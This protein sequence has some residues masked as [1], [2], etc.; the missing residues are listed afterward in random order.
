MI[1]QRQSRSTLMSRYQVLEA[2]WQMHRARRRY[3]WRV[4]VRS[5]S[6]GVSEKKNLHHKRRRS[7]SQPSRDPQTKSV[8]LVA[9]FSSLKR[10]IRLILSMTVSSTTISSTHLTLRL[11]GLTPR[12]SHR[13]FQRKLMSI[14]KS[15][16]CSNAN[17]SH[18]SI[19]T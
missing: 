3:Q 10:S 2:N 15:M 7:Q 16:R 1:L 13:I 11:S 8:D 17:H 18:T 5:S 4:S 12:S 9:L 6:D 14:N 19:D